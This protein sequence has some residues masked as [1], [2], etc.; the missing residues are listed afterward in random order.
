MTTLT[1]MI[2]SNSFMDLLV[3]SYFLSQEQI[4]QLPPEEARGLVLNTQYSVLY[5]KRT[6][7][8]DNLSEM[9]PYNTIPK[10]FM[11]LD[12]Q[13]LEASGI[14]QVQTQPILNLSGSGVLLGFIDSGIDY[15]HPAFLDSSGHSRI[16]S[17]W[18]QTDRSGTPPVHLP[19]GSVYDK[20]E[21]DR[22]LSSDS[23]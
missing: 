20:N 17:I 13:P 19:Y 7:E 10:L 12:T 9:F 4:Q 5:L 16:L 1:D 18:D 23:P 15:T 11:P 6:A 21:I 3:R 8:I 2:Y 22:A 14:R